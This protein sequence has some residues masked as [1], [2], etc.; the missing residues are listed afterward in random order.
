M[1]MLVKIVVWIFILRLCKKCIR[2]A[3][4]SAPQRNQKNR[5]VAKSAY[6]CHCSVFM[7]TAEKALNKKRKVEEQLSSFTSLCRREMVL[8]LNVLAVR[9]D[10]KRES[11]TSCYT[12][13]LV[14]KGK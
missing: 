3:R 10:T 8:T 7:L 2:T 12:K 14:K 4:C 13:I 5:T 9:I 11:I 6:L 1:S